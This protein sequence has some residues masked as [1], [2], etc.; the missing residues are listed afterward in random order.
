M[1]KSSTSSSEALI[2]LLFWVVVI[3]AVVYFVVRENHGKIFL[4][5]S[6]R[7]ELISGVVIF[8]GIPVREGALHLVVAE[9]RSRRY[10][11]GI[12][13]P[14]KN[15]KFSSQ[16]Q[17]PLGFADSSR[18]WRITAEFHGT[19]VEKEDGKQKIL[20]VTGETTRYLNTSPPLGERFLWGVTI[21]VGILLFFQLVLFTGDLGS[22]KARLLFV[23]MYFF[24]FFS[25][26]MPIAVSLVVAR[27]EDLVHSMEVSPIGLVKAKTSAS[28]EQQWLVNIGGRVRLADEDDEDEVERAPRPA[29]ANTSDAQAER[30]LEG[31]GAESPEIDATPATASTSAVQSEGTVESDAAAAPASETTISPTT[32]GKDIYETVKVVEGGVA[33]PFYVVLLAMFGAGINMTLKVPVIQ[34]SYEDVLPE[35]STSWWIHSLAAPWRLLRGQTEA[36]ASMISGK[37]AGDIRRDLIENFM[38]LLSAPLLAI[39]MYY[40]LQVLAEEVTQ[41]VL[42]LMAFAT[43]L[44][45]KAVVGGIIQFAESRLLTARE[46]DVEPSEF[47]NAVA[48]VQ[49]KQAEAEAAERALEEARINLAA[50]EAAAHAAEEAAR[51]TNEITSSDPEVAKRETEKA[52]QEAAAK[53]AEAEEAQRV[54]AKAEQRVEE[55]QAEAKKAASAVEQVQLREIEAATRAAQQAEEKQAEARAAAEATEDAAKAA[56]AK[57]AAA[58]EA[59][60]AVTQQPAV[61]DAEAKPSSG[62]D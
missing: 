50:A 62:S 60:S 16:G 47:A 4:D 32:A 46:R 34:R 3:G 12:T 35:D 11:A 48:K 40:L 15:G 30:T 59:V 5:V 49:V 51:K 61:E 42:V 31:D 58:Q 29:P 18:A 9:A 41:P 20:V 44:V 10:Q 23:L 57:Q 28:S 21:V 8:E 24:T 1:S 45:S 22:K 14:V 55:K 19:A 54:A 39:A 43:G 6:T 36:S 17:P 27:Y 26:A 33:V 52:A 13:L 2:G 25:L 53:R 56:T 38:Y 37:T 7:P